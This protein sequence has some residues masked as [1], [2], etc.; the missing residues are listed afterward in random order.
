MAKLNTKIRYLCQDKDGGV[1]ASISSKP[2]IRHE[3]WF[4]CDIY[5]IY[6]GKE[7]PNWR[8]TLIDLETDDYDFADGILWRIEK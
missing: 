8:N 4:E 1:H 6:D 7:N 3:E 5:H 2:I